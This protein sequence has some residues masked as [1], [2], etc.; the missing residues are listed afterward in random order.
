MSLAISPGLTDYTPFILSNCGASEFKKIFKDLND[1]LRAAL[2]REY[3]HH[4]SLARSEKALHGKNR[5]ADIRK[6]LAAAETA[7]KKLRNEL[8]QIPEAVWLSSPSMPPTEQVDN[9][10]LGLAA[11]VVWAQDLPNGKLEKTYRDRLAAGIA[12]AM[13]AAGIAAK[14][15]HNNAGD[16]R[17]E[18][19]VRLALEEVDGQASSNVFDIMKAGLQYSR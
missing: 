15:N 8:E 6:R 12:K 13:E 5:V 17:Y 3:C 2:L 14:L 4:C 7:A 18:D 1:E 19:A 9:I 11:S 10:L 16:T